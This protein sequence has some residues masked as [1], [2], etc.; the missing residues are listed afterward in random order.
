L[1]TLIGLNNSSQLFREYKSPDE[2]FCNF[3]FDY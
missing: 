3:S 1:N 2:M